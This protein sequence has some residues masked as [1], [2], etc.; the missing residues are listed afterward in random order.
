[1]VKITDNV[2]ETLSTEDSVELGARDLIDLKYASFNA[3][4]EDVDTDT[5]VYN[6]NAGYSMN[7][8]TNDDAEFEEHEEGEAR[9]GVG[10]RDKK[11]LHGEK[12]WLVRWGS[13]DRSGRLFS[14][15]PISTLQNV[16][17]KT[18]SASLINKSRNFITH[19][20]FPSTR[21]VACVC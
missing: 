15:R 2:T 8:G 10:G 7:S 20:L 1:M 18:N 6:A 16:K 12:T 4:D 13:R 9:V 3:I 14:D 21:C 17:R 11:Q 19:A 5:H